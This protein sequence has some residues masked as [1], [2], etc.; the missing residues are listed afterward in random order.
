MPARDSFRGFLRWLA[1]PPDESESERAYSEQ[2][3][4]R[5]KLNDDEFYATFYGG[6]GIQKDIPIRLRKLYEKIIG[7]DLSALH[8][9]DDQALIYDGLD[10]LDVLYR[11]QREFKLTIPPAARE[12]GPP[13]ASPSSE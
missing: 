13:P 7:E 6:T 3:Q 4:L 1:G 9:E 2:L 8:P 5:T 12:T 10:F 11:V